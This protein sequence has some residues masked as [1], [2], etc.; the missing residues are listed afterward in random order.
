MK[1]NQN[2][3]LYCENTTRI[4]AYVDIQMVLSNG[5]NTSLSGVRQ[6]GSNL[7][8]STRE[9][10]VAE[11]LQDNRAKVEGVVVFCQLTTLRLNGTRLTPNP[12]EDYNFTRFVLLDETGGKG[13]GKCVVRIMLQALKIYT[14]EVIGLREYSIA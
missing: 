13:K 5:S 7:V 6:D 2:V 14:S 10:L 9:I 8:N 4:I 1:S 3:T 12:P 11:L